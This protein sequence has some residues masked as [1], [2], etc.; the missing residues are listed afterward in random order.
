MNPRLL[1]RIAPDGQFAWLAPATATRGGGAPPA[2]LAAAANEIVVVVPGEDVL[3]TRA[4]LPKSSAARLAQVLPYALEDQVLGT[5]E[6]QHF[7]LGP[8]GDDGRHAVAV[9]TRDR[10]DAWLRQLREAGVEADVLLPET[11][12][13]PLRGV[14]P[15]VLLDGSRCTVRTDSARGFVCP[16]GQLAAWLPPGLADAH[17]DGYAAAGATTAALPASLHVDWVPGSDRGNPGSTLLDVFAHGIGETPA[18]NLLQGAHAPRHRRAPQRRLWKIAAVLAGTAL[19]L[20]LLGKV[21]DVLRLRSAS[22]EADA[23]IAAIY[24]QSFP[25]SPQVPDPVARMQSELQ[26]LGGDSHAGG[27]LPLLSHVAPILAS[28]DF[29]LRMQGLEYR[30]D[31]LELSLHA[32]SLDSLDQLRERLAT[33]PGVSVDLTAV[34]PGND[35]VDGRLRI[36]GGGA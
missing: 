2:D 36:R 4:E 23:A 14:Q 26:R 30:N 24:A 29:R 25:G 6:E 34:T 35:G 18:L 31:T 16:I 33:L 7:A 8:A 10:L 12:A 17:F 32:R 9:V 15:A 13:V 28:Q 22:H 1:I 5:V 11:L 20:G 19:L 27:L 3:L 21:V